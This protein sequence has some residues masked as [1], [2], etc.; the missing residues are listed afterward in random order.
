MTP[1]E[2]LDERLT[3]LER[4]HVCDEAERK[5]RQLCDPLYYETRLDRHLAILTACIKL[6]WGW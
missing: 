2:R 5:A 3:D 1:Q 4:M 6:R